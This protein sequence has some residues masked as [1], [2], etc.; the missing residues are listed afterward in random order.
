MYT[1]LLDPDIPLHH[2]I[3]N[4]LRAEI[5]DGL[6]VGR[7]DFPGER[8]LA[9]T[10]GVSVITSR[11]ALDRLTAE[12]FI[13][14]GRGRRPR[15]LHGPS[16]PKTKRL[17]V[18]VLPL[19]PLR[20]YRYKVLFAGVAIAAAEACA[21]FELPP[22]SH[23]WQCRRLRL[24]RGK[25]HSVTHNVQLPEVGTRHADAQLQ[26]LPM[27]QILEKAGFRLATVRRRVSVGLPQAEVAL[28]LGITVQDPTLIY[29]FTVSD[30]TGRVAEWVR[31]QVHPRESAP[32]ESFDIRTGTW[33][34]AEPM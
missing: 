29:S 10:F 12:S 17:A 20:P 23:L 33:H 34:A 1:E 27:G 30:D 8:E 18:T 19:G 5:L 4:Q 15:V 32:L 3:Y 25:P 22:G 14:R 13:A 16:L 2:Q 7:A 21:A 26:R 6:W 28:H 24:F 31:I 11:A 9:Q